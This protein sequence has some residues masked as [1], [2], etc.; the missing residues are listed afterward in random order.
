MLGTFVLPN[1]KGL[2]FSFYS[3]VCHHITLLWCVTVYLPTLKVSGYELAHSVTPKKSW[4]KTFDFLRLC[5]GH[6]VCQLS[7]WCEGFATQKHYGSSSCYSCIVEEVVVWVLSHTETF[8]MLHWT[9]AYVKRDVLHLCA[10][11]YFITRTQNSFSDA[12]FG[13]LL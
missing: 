2:A 1:C 13:I 6:C 4:Y 3:M 9:D 10:I 8:I 11:I 12:V 5:N 7:W